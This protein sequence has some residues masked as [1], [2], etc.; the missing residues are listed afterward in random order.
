MHASEP[1]YTPT[2]PRR[3][4]LVSRIRERLTRSARPVPPPAPLEDP[5]PVTPPNFHGFYAPDG[6]GDYIVVAYPLGAEYRFPASPVL[7]GELLVRYA[8]LVA[9]AGEPLN[10][11]GD[12]VTSYPIGTHEEGAG[13]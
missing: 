5:R 13:R 11:D 3:R 8:E 9:L 6:S 2:R 7:T 12:G 4:S 1:H 10:V